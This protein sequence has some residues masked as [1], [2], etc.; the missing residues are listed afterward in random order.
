VRADLKLDF[1][2]IVEFGMEVEAS[3]LQ[4]NISSDYPWESCESCGCPAPPTTRTGKTCT[5]LWLAQMAR[6]VA[7]GAAC[8]HGSKPAHTTC[9]A[10]REQAKAGKPSE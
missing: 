6:F 10:G 3:F 7:D 9:K 2:S 1:V 4:G 5:T 8:C